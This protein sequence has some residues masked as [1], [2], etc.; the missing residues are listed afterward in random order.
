[1]HFLQRIIERI[2]KTIESKKQKK[3]HSHKITKQSN[4]GV[5]EGRTL[6]WYL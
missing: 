2:R 6:E 3:D 4:S 1:M 5:T